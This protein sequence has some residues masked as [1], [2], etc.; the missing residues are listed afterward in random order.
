MLK[1]DLS[2]LL[3]KTPAMKQMVEQKVVE[4]AAKVTLDVHANVV[5]GSPVDT[6]A[7][8]GAWTVETPTQPFENGKVE[9]TTPYGPQLVDGHSGQA[10]KGWIDNAVLAATRL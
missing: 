9:N 4:V 10:P 7:F 6:G 1:I 3:S 5:A 8:R 2:D